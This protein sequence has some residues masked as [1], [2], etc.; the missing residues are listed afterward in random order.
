MGKL[1]WYVARSVIVAIL[2]V[3]S[4]MLGLDSLFGLIEELSDVDEQYRA[5]DA[6]Q[7]VVLSMPGRAVLYVPYSALVGCLIGLG[8]LA[9][10]SELV[11]M[12]ASG[13]STFRI[14]RFVLQPVLV[15]V[16]AAMLLGEF[17]TPRIDQYAV[18]Q[19]NAALGGQSMSSDSGFWSR[20]GQEFVHINGVS[21]EGHL[22]GISRYQYGD[23]GRLLVSSFAQSAQYQK[24]HWLEKNVVVTSLSDAGSFTES[25]PQRQWQTPLKPKLLDVLAISEDALGIVDL[26]SYANYRQSQGLK[27]DKYWLVFWEKA[28]QPVATISLVL[29]AISF[30]FGP[31]RQVTTGFR[32]FIGVMVGVVFKTAQAILGPSSLVFGF[33]PLLAVMV[34][35]VVC[36]AGGLWMI[37]R[38]R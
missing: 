2:A 9:G 32:V 12:R 25:L 7:F 38:Y 28:L 18:A 23:D 27:S 3:L 24:T 19:R 8:M 15:F 26:Y 16:L 14:S 22:L 17:V 34:P 36:L 33:S 1:S 31:L 13:V 35:I 20:D 29:V 10:T 30:I 5:L 6:F 37:T 11:I 21:G 4:V